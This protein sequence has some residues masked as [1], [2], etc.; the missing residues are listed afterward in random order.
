[1]N[2]S[3]YWCSFGLVVVGFVLPTSAA[4]VVAGLFFLATSA[5]LVVLDLF[6]LAI[7][8]AFVVVGFVSFLTSSIDE[9]LYSTED[10]IFGEVKAMN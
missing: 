10:R 3:S 4:L 2:R 1:M 9:L 8:A 7:S 5:A 6:F